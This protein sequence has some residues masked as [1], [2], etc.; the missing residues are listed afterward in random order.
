MYLPPMPSKGFLFF[1][2]TGISSVGS[3]FGNKKVME[4]NLAGETI[5]ENTVENIIKYMGREP[6]LPSKIWWFF[7][8]LYVSLA[9]L[10]TL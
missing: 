6:S 2:I 8:F 5:P 1:Q 10:K 3:L 9:I 4:L 7:R